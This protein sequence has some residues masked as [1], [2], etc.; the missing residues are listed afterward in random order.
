MSCNIDAWKTKKIEDLNIPMS[1]FYQHERKDY[2]PSQPIVINFETMEV[3]IKHCGQGTMKGILKDG[4]LNVSEFS[5]ITSDG[6]NIF[7]KIL[8][9][10]LKESTGILQVRTTWEGDFDCIELNSIN[11]VVTEKT[12]EI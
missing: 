3:V 5:G 6:S 12:I 2:H 8:K 11:G 4:I 7:Y 9:E 1:A 10:A